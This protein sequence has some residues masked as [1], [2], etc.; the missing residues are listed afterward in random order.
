M[1]YVFS[2]KKGIITIVVLTHK[3]FRKK[4]T[5]RAIVFYCFM[6]VIETI[7]FHI[8]TKLIPCLQKVENAPTAVPYKVL[9]TLLISRQKK[10][11]KKLP[12]GRKL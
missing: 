11:K 9:S 10:K 12:N 4:R 5:K 1:N 8:C 3:F 7:L 6:F 2:R